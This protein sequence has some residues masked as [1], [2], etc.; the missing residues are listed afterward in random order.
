M[1]RSPQPTYKIASSFPPLDRLL[2]ADQFKT[3]N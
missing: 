1:P 2:N 3:T